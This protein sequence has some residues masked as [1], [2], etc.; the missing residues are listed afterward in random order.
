MRALAGNPHVH[1]DEISVQVDGDDAVLRGT[2]GSLVQQAEAMGAARGVPGVHSVVDELQVRPL[3]ID[4]QANAD[5]EAAVLDALLDDDDLAPEGL[6]VESRGGAV[7]LRGSLDLAPQRETAERIALAVPGVA[8][9]ENRLSVRR[10]VSAD[11][12]AE[13]VT[14][15]DRLVMHPHAG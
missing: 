5:T 10:T 6:V 12:V 7:T 9:V 13:R 15:R 2:V 3:G 4:G 14:V 8:S 1:A 11:D